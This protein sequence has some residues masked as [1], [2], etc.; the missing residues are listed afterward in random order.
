M[1]KKLMITC[2]SL[3]IFFLYGCDNGKL[4]RP[5]AE[6][7]LLSDYPKSIT[8]LVRMHE[9]DFGRSYTEAPIDIQKLKN[10]GILTYDLVPAGTSGYGCD[11]ELTD[12]G[13]KYL[14]NT[15]NS[16]A[17][18][19]RLISAQI[20]FSEI[21][22]IREIPANNSAIVEY[23]EKVTQITPIGRVLD[24]IQSGQTENK[25][26]TFIKSDNGW[27]KAASPE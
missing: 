1:K 10:L 5:N 27:H 12:E 23:T 15:E 21:T 11:A 18:Y 4:S 17:G 25:Q 14:S 2:L 20:G 8:V 16:P 24:K 3:L 7:I 9:H 13:K 6:K 26:A 19:I 22:S